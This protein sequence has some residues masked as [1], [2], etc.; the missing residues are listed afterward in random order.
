MKMTSFLDPAMVGLTKIPP[1]Q[2][3]EQKYW[4]WMNFRERYITTLDPFGA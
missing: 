1:D 4:W 2:S 3:G